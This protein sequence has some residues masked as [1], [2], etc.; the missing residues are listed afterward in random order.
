MAARVTHK[1]IKALNNSRLKP[2]I[3]G[4]VYKKNVYLHNV[5]SAK[6]VGVR[7]HYGCALEACVWLCRG[8]LQARACRNL[9]DRSGHSY[10]HHS[11]T[12]HSYTRHSIYTSLYIH[13][14]LYTRH[15]IY[16]SLYIHVT[17]YTRHSLYTSLCIKICI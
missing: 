7:R 17:L 5:W 6:M 16:T 12:C 13:I 2:I 4:V 8:A 1:S 9:S 11:Y 14:T 15:S 10:T 3:L